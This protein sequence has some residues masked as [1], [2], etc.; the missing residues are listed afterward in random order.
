LNHML[1]AYFHTFQLRF[2]KLDRHSEVWVSFALLI[3][4]N[5]N[6]FASHRLT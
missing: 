3:C 1:T 2:L 6:C 5:Y 4:L